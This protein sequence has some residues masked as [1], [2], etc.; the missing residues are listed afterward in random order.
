ERN[1]CPHMPDSAV[2]FPGR[3]ACT[4]RHRDQ[5]LLPSTSRVGR[6]FVPD[7]KSRA[8]AAAVNLIGGACNWKSLA[9]PKQTYRSKDE[10]S[11]NISIAA[12]SRSGMNVVH[13]VDFLRIRFHIRQVQIHDDG[14][15][16]AATQHA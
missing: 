9:G 10:W 7:S 8:R 12:N 13:P 11:R 15:L 5:R 14:F 3:E 16:P 1:A 6:R 4:C 2:G